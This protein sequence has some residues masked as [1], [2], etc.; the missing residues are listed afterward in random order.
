MP[1]VPE[2]GD[3]LVRA[4]SVVV[5]AGGRKLLDGV[6]I[7]LRAGEVLA[8]VGP[9]GAGKSTLLAALAGDLKLASG[10]VSVHGA[11]I[12]RWSTVELARLRAVLPQNNPLS[13]PFDVVSVVRMGRVPWAG[14]EAEDD[15]E[16]EVAAALA[17]TEMVE[18]ATRRFSTLSGGEH[19]RAAL[20]RVLAQS[21]SVLLLDEPTA[22]MDLRHQEQVL[23]LARAKAAAGAAVLVVL[24]DLGLAAAHADRIAVLSGGRI[25]DIGPPDLVCRPDLLSDVYRN[26]V[27]VIAHPRTGKPIVLPFRN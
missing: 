4:E 12:G 20:A 11:P 24:H 9:N 2:H 1:G 16:T 19:A 7:G 8:L 13:F 6:D 17:D 18:M 23:V 3:V 10:V 5:E 15:D 14:T 21:T 25:A 22:A 27:E 26:P